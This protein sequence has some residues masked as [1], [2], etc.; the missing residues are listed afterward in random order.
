MKEWTSNLPTFHPSNPPFCHSFSFVLMGFGFSE[1]SMACIDQ[2]RQLGILRV[3][4]LV[5]PSHAEM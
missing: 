3:T 1:L 4:G 5:T 2:F